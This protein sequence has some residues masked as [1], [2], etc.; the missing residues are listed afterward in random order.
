MPDRPFPSDSQEARTRFCD[1][2]VAMG[3]VAACVV[4]AL[5]ILAAGIFDTG[6]KEMTQPPRPVTTQSEFRHRLSRS[7]A[8]KRRQQATLIQYKIPTSIRVFFEGDQTNGR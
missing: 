1:R 5:A 4:M 6:E 2:Y 7:Q 8:P 3:I